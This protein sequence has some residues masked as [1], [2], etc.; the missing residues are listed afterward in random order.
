MKSAVRQGAT[1]DWSGRQCIK[2]LLTQGKNGVET[3]AGSSKNRFRNSRSNRKIPPNDLSP[4]TDK[5][6]E[7][8]HAQFS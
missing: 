7:T 1:A 2:L 4:E 5:R 3:G 6:N 8:V